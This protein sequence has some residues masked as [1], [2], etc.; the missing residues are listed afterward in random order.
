MTIENLI[1][2]ELSRCRGYVAGIIDGEGSIGIYKRV[3]RPAA[4][5]LQ[6]HMTDREPLDICKMILGGGSIT[7]YKRDECRKD[8]WHYTISGK[9][10]L[11]KAL[12][13]IAPYLIIKKPQADLVLM[14][15]DDPSPDHDAYK[16]ASFIL[17]GR[18]IPPEVKT[19]FLK[20]LEGGK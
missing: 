12:E 8:I 2:Q 1:Y 17:S 10:Q 9:R 13:L 5:M 19:H 15:I 14:Y 4:C 3:D 20:V 11:K 6:I 16:K 7:K 18:K